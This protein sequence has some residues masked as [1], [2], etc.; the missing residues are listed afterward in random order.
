MRL[1]T[2]MRYGTRAMLYLALHAADG[3]CSVQEI[4]ADQ[5]LSVKYLEHL[6]SAVLAEGLVRSV[7][8]AGGGYLLA[9]APDQIRLSRLL[10]A[11]EGERGLV[12]CTSDPAACPRSGT[13]ITQEVWAEMYEACRRVLEATTLGDLAQRHQ[14]KMAQTGALPF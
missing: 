10:D 5:G 7:R 12:E 13:C 11:F 9:D 14:A 1:S 4:A 3:P 8:G 6:M 2:R